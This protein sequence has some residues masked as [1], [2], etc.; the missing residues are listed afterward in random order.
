M[1]GV[2]VC[3]ECFEESLRVERELRHLLAVVDAAA[4]EEAQ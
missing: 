1:D 2:P 4:R 3:S